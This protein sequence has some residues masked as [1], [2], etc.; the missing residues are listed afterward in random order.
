MKRMKK[1]KKVLLLLFATTML[2][3][4]RLHSQQPLQCK[5]LIQICNSNAAVSS[6]ASTQAKQTHITKREVVSVNTIL[7]N[8][9]PFNIKQFVTKSIYITNHQF[10]I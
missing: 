4:A 8:T 9:Q 2:I 3:G 1:M 6:N 5:Q 7:N 10:L